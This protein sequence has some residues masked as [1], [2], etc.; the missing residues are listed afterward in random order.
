MKS[1]CKGEKLTYF[2]ILYQ[3]L[4]RRY[5]RTCMM[6]FFVFMM[7]AT[8]FSSSLI[9]RS[10]ELGLESTANRM[11]ADIIIVPNGY[12]SALQNA[13]FMGKPCTIY[14]NKD[15]MDEIGNIDG[16]QQLSYQMYL[17][18]LSDS[19]CCDNEVQVIALDPDS[20]FVIQP[21][22]QRNLLES[23]GEK[24]ILVGHNIIY[25]AGDTA[26]Y[27]G[28]SFTVA[29]KLDKTGMGYDN[30]VFLTYNDANELAQKPITRNYFSLGSGEN[31]I[32]L[33][34]LNVAEGYDIV[35]VSNKITATYGNDG[36][37]VYTSDSLLSGLSDG[38]KTYSAYGSV[39]R[40]L[41]F[42]LTVA[43]LFSIFTITINERKR[44]FGILIMIG[45]SRGK[46]I[47]FIVGEAAAICF[48]GC[49]M[50]LIVSGI[51]LF[52][53]HNLIIVKLSMPFL[54]PR[55]DEMISIACKCFIVSILSG[56]I[57]SI[58]SAIE[59]GGAEPYLLIKEDEA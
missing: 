9:S 49:L 28:T 13:L 4:T 51:V 24:Q 23:L 19:E 52:A 37:S 36:I 34:T 32:S 10:L 5:H 12:V 14:F 27:Y 26:T 48:I 17:A 42:I 22:I 47:R 15:W 29:A 30:S 11:G 16:V 56:F 25:E 46:I 7:S 18:T 33:I 31:L 21:W 8:V 1:K 45:A 2:K 3:N 57:A 20:D 38:I 58:F 50:G 54:V 6:L 59:V 35:T 55:I 53:F 41:M 40:G 44:E 39:I 43:A